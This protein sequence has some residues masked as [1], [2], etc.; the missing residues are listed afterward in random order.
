MTSF[1]RKP[2]ATILDLM[3]SM[4]DAHI[5]EEEWAAKEA[6]LDEKEAKYIRQ[7]NTKEIDEDRFRELVA[8]LDLE[9]AMGE[10]VAEGPAMTQ[11]TTQDEEVR[12]S[13]QEELAE[14]EPEAAERVV[15]SSTGSKGKRKA[16][17]ARAKVY[18]EVEVLNYIM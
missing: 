5:A 14:E 1:L 16:A 8:E 6:E 11:V 17:P 13:E 10:S 2:K 4:P 18:A 12:E 3:K 9:R 15:E 7:V